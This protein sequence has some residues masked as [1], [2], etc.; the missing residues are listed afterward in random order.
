LLDGNEEAFGQLLKECKDASLLIISNHASTTYFKK[1]PRL[2][3][4]ATGCGVNIL[5]ESAL[6]EEMDEFRHLFSGSDTDLQYILSCIRLG[7]EEN[8]R[9]ILLWALK[10]IGGMDIMVPPLTR[11]PADGCY[12]PSLPGDTSFETH[13]ARLDPAKP[14]IGIFM[15][16]SGFIRR[17]FRVIDALIEAVEK[18]GMNALG[19]FFNT[20]YDPVIGSLGIKK[21]VEEYLIRDGK[22]LV[23]CIIINTGFSQVSL[24]DPN[25][26]TRKT[27]PHNFFADLNIPVI[28]AMTLFRS[29]ETWSEDIQGLSSMEISNHVI[30]PEFDGQIITIPVGTSEKTE[31]GESIAVPI[32]G[33]PERV[34]DM[35]LLW[36]RIRRKPAGERKVAILIYQ[37]TGDTDT[38]GHA[39]SLDTPQSVV[40]M[41]RYLKESGYRVDHIPADGNALIQEMIRGLTNDVRYLSPEQVRKRSPGFVT[42]SQYREWFER[43]PRKNREKMTAD[44][45]EPPGELFRSDGEL[46]MPGVMN[47]NIFIGIQPPRGYFE[48]AESLIHS[49]DLVMPHH[50]LAY[51]RWLKHSFGADAV[52]HVGT[53]G[54]LEWLPGKGNALSEECYPDLIFED[55]PHLY[56]YIINDPGEAVQAKRRSWAVILDHLVPVMMRAEGYGELSDL[57]SILQEYLR[58]KTVGDSA[59]VASLLKEAHTIVTGKNFTKDLDL[60][61]TIT[62]E[63]IIPHIERIYDYICGLRDTIIRD[64]LHVFGVPPREKLCREMV[65]SLTRL[66]NGDVISLRECVA[67][68]HGLHLR[69]LMND[70]SAWNTENGQTNGSLLDRVDGEC[71][72]LIL[73]LAS[74]GYDYETFMKRIQTESGA[75]SGSLQGCISY[76]CNSIAP[77][78]NGTTDE[79]SN[80]GLGLAGGY[81]PPGPSGDPTRGNAHLL[82]TG[83]NCYSI[84]PATIPTPSAWRTGKELADQMIERYISQEGTYPER[85][86]IVVW[87]TDTM[88]T[89]GDDIAYILSLMGL[90]PV[91][92]HRGGTVTGLE[93]IPVSELDRPRIDVTLR[94]SGLF[95]DAFPNLVDMIDKGVEICASLDESAESN[96]LA[97]HLKHD[98]LKKLA[99]GISPETAREMSLIRIFGDPP[100]NYGAGVSDVVHASV[101]NERKDLADTYTTWGAHAYGRRFKGEKYV[102]LFKEQFGSL[103]AT[104]KNR[105]SR[106][107]DVLDTDDEYMFLGGM[108]AC[109][110]SYGDK[111]PVS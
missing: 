53:H 96:Y 92:S 93:I 3:Q 77:G 109:V 63:G 4:A 76:I 68:S 85:V 30:W 32:P 27:F 58:A 67:D 33:R 57:D 31:S 110:K 87:A 66:S 16:H 104:V 55:M 43:I 41:L 19:V 61:D 106:E 14:S 42:S 73:N 49:N 54:T 56:P 44:W 18:K 22:S 36:S 39:A 69:D 23:D 12:H 102:D 17:N 71:Q 38:L 78:L 50:Y 79:L 101:W 45:G 72:D 35:A 62:P 7:G 59:K 97:A 13:L 52:I 10:N 24:S 28:Q 26:G 94:I 29:Q 60:P 95:R 11:P 6:S 5:V 82:P 21:I 81:V 20:S 100:G 91:W 80:M 15:H 64:G 89:G 88:R 84:D 83:K 90:R 48:Q 98:L 37:Y 111:D 2:L 9:G 65:Y 99:E 75:L 86:G 107:Y 51:Y 1:F 8:T 108:N 40:E 25:D 47:G 70:P 46:C 34:A 103:D 74:C 105:P